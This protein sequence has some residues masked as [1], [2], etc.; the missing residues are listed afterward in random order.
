MS[1]EERRSVTVSSSSNSHSGRRPVK[2]WNAN[3]NV[4]K[5]LVVGTYEEFLRKG[6]EKLSVSIGEPLRIVLESDGTQVEDGEYFQTLPENTIFI[7]LRPG[8][9][10]APAGEDI[11]SQV[12][13][14]IPKIVC[15]TLAALGLQ[16]EIPSWKIMDN[17]GKITVVLHWEKDHPPGQPPSL[18]VGPGGS[19]SVSRVT[20]RQSSTCSTIA[21][22]GPRLLGV[23]TRGA[24]QR[25]VS[26]SVNST[27]CLS[28]DNSRNSAGSGPQVGTQQ[29]NMHVQTSF[30]SGFSVHS[31]LGKDSKRETVMNEVYKK[32]L[33]GNA[34]SQPTPLVTV[35][36]ADSEQV[37]AKGT[38]SGSGTYL[39]TRPIISGAPS[40]RQ[41]SRQGSSIESSTVH[42][43]TVECAGSARL[44]QPVT[45][46]S[47][48]SP[49]SN[50]C[51]FH[52]CS[53]HAGHVNN[54]SSHKNAT[55]SPV[56]AE[57]GKRTL[58]KGAHVRFDVES[59]GAGVTANSKCNFA[60]ET[61]FYRSDLH[62]KSHF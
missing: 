3:R 21:Q 12:V 25:S 11:V 27:P 4:R 5:A 13:S 36:N 30:D 26:G 42:T 19:S 8:E 59:L 44:H 54:H 58:P 39:C 38:T 6:R 48:G 22:G 7:V 33:S 35:I 2:I 20:S 50:E 52:C 16:E 45:S 57:E 31:Y 14:T 40:P 28:R 18:Q 24:S 51:D 62:F 29:N 17:K 43:H 9:N 60:T 46:H 41:L 10:W 47:R 34:T 23:H 61:A 37:G 32:G 1:G 49:T 55:T 15:E 53:L 56:Q